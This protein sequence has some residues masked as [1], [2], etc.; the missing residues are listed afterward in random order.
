MIRVLTA[1]AISLI[2]I[3]IAGL[4]ITSLGKLLLYANEFKVGDISSATPVALGI[5]LVVLIG[6]MLWDAMGQRRA[7]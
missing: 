1:L 7:T 3:G 6:A 2:A 5:T 4:I